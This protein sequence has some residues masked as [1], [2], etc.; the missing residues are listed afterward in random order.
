ML[1][2][3]RSGSLFLRGA[4]LP[5][6]LGG[7]VLSQ[8]HKGHASSARGGEEVYLTCTLTWYITVSRGSVAPNILQL[9]QYYIWNISAV[10]HSPQRDSTMGRPQDCHCNY[11]RG[12]LYTSQSLSGINTRRDSLSH[13]TN[14]SPRGRG[15]HGSLVDWALCVLPLLLLWSVTFRHQLHSQPTHSLCRPLRTLRR[16][17]DTIIPTVGASI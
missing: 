10:Y 16:S 8:L 9:K 3:K 11:A 17:V 1:L 4:Y 6:S 14:T 13:P 7:S 12:M 15:F 2:G 5:W